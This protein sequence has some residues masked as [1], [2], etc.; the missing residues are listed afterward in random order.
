M[1]CL[2]RNLCNSCGTNRSSSCCDNDV[3]MRVVNASNGGCGCGWNHGGS[4]VVI[5]NGGCGCNSCNGCGYNYNTASGCGCDAYDT[6]NTCGC[7]Y[8]TAST[9]GCGY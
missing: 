1:C 2:F 4:V 3:E 5:S 9:C 6:A 7:G 8:N